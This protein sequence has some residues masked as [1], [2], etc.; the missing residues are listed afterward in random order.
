LEG[1]R[2][3]RSLPRPQLRDYPAAALEFALAAWTLK[4]EEEYRSAAV[5]AEIVAALLD[6]GA[7]L[8]LLAALGHVVEDELA[9]SALCLDLVTAFGAPAP[10][11]SMDRVR[12]R[13]SADGNTSPSMKGLKLLLFEGAIG[14]TISARLFHAGW[15]VSRE[16]CTRAAL[17]VILRD[18]ARHARLCWHASTELVRG[19]GNPERTRLQDDLADFLGNLEHSAALPAL[20][21][22]E[23]NERV[24][25][26]L[27]ELGVLAAEKRVSAFY[28]SLEK[29]AFPR[30]ARL[31]FDAHHA[32]ATRYQR[33]VR[34]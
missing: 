3:A 16:P 34:Q 29:V 19:L 30:L 9:H 26:E 7:P 12:Q 24:P 14:E 18:E 5:F 15:A 32:W 10:K 20:R 31:G 17:R 11:A 8:D 23:A 25:T 21:R 22:L 4:A 6:G 2:L 13:V 33:R 1:N 27:E 28:D